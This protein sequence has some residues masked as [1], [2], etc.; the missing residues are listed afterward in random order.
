[1]VREVYYE[2]HIDLQNYQIRKD[3]PDIK[4]YSSKYRKSFVLCL[5]KCGN[6]R[7]ETERR[8]ELKRGSKIYLYIPQDRVRGYMV[9]TARGKIK[10]Y[11]M[12][13]KHQVGYMYNGLLS[14]LYACLND[15][16]LS[17]NKVIFKVPVKFDKFNKLLERVW[18]D[19]GCKI[20]VKIKYLW[21]PK[22]VEILGRTYKTWR[23]K[24]LA[25]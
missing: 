24:K 3:D 5:Q 9:L 25:N 21:V 4:L 11:G 15:A 19:I 10:D 23:W 14:L 17:M 7:L 2:Y 18:C 22:K 16:S 12:Y 1:M 6:K 13:G 8:I 20:D